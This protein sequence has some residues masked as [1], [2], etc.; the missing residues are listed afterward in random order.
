MRGRSRIRLVVQHDRSP[1]EPQ[2]QE[3]P[4]P[5]QLS[6]QV[7]FFIWLDLLAFKHGGQGH[8]GLANKRPG[9]RRQAVEP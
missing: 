8:I 4:Q 7:Q 6:A 5:T 1:G 3:R 9:G 2:V